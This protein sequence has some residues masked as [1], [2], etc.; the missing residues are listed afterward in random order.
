MNETI[1]GDVFGGVGIPIYLPEPDDFLKVKETLTRLG[2]AS[3]K[4]KTLYQSCHILHKR[5]E[6][7]IL[8]FKELFV[9]DGK[10]S[11]IDLDDIDRRNAIVNL[12]ETWGLVTLA[13]PDSVDR[14][15]RAMLGRLKVLAF[16]DKREWRLISKYQVGKK[17]NNDDG[18]TSFNR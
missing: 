18:R 11:S 6:Y 14:S 4:T 9:L 5:G 2:V 3:E 7:A 13:Y 16:K 10:P 15:D 1:Y 8:H 12:L 17:G